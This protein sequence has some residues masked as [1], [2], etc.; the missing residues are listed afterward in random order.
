VY[1]YKR[2]TIP[3]VAEI[4]LLFLLLSIL[5]PAFLKAQEVQL[6]EVD[7]A[8]SDTTDTEFQR[9][10]R[11][12]YTGRLVASP[13]LRYYP[14]LYYIGLP[15]ES[16][17]V[18]R[19]EDGR[20]QAIDYIHQMPVGL[21]GIYSFEEYRELSRKESMRY[22][23]SQLIE[24]FD[25]I[26]DEDRG[27][28]DFRFT[29]PGG[30]ESA[31]TT[32]FGRP[33]INLR[34]NGVANMNIGASIQQTADPSLPPDQQTRVDPTFDQN[35]QLNIQGTI[36]DKLTIQTDWD[37]ERTFDYQNR[38]SIAY[39]GYEDEIIR[40]IE[41]GNVS[42]QTGNSLIRGSGSLFG[43]KSVAELGALRFTSVLSQQKGESNIETI[44]GG[45]QE[46]PIN[47][48]PA[49]YEND[50]HFFMDFYTRQEFEQSLANPQ[51]AL[52]TL[53]ISEVNVWV[54]SEQVQAEEGARLAVALADYG[55]VENPDGTYA[56]PN[57]QFDRFDQSIIDAFRDPTVGISASDIGIDDP[58]NFEEG[59]FRLLREGEEY[60]LNRTSGYISLNRTL[61]SREV[62]AV[63]FS[64]VGPGGENINVGDVNQ[65]GSERIFLKMLRPGRQS[66]D[67]RVFPLTMRNVYS[68]G[69]I[70]LTRNN[71]DLDLQFTEGSVAQDRL[72]GRNTTML[73]DLGLD[74]VDSQG[75]LIPITRLILVPEHWMQQMDASSFLTLNHLAAGWKKYYWKQELR[76]QT[77]NAL[78]I[79]SYTKSSVQMLNVHPKTIFTGLTVL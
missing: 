74:R 77:W 53:Q 62:L 12:P 44:T 8:T 71:I 52:Q 65:G 2:R 70:D 63:S 21:P 34:V 45:S 54:L 15:A 38:L 60:T 14:R 24:E 49:D 6:P 16:V 40:S 61:S 33:E 66:T 28:L 5:L 42:M 27:L 9:V 48:R 67:H 41:M 47:L 39:E 30:R 57:N 79:M 26:D 29:I 72:P 43:I 50:R 51:Q 4:F 23:W 18:E 11:S 76:M 37:T 32:I 20:Y 7:T 13:Y 31:F 1:S 78:S 55:V 59:Y 36:G 17:Q 3:L 73:Q 19:L 69:A 64:Y 68:L 75:A 25:L 22:N 46:R 35:L 56:P 10:F 58:R